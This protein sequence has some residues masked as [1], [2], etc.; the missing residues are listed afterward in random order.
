METKTQG[1]EV[2]SLRSHTEWV[3]E[4]GT[5]PLTPNDDPQLVISAGVKRTLDLE[6][7][8]PDLSCFYFFLGF[9]LICNMG[10]TT[11]PRPL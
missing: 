10:A 7:G 9:S 3:T 5:E 6:I 2:T 1:Y 4:P 11:V 8:W